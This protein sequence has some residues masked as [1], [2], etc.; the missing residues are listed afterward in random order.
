MRRL[1]R[2][3]IGLTGDAETMFLA[4]AANVVFPGRGL[5]PRLADFGSGLRLRVRAFAGVD[6]S[7][8]PFPADQ[9]DCRPVLIAKPVPGERSRPEGRGEHRADDA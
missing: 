9:M 7:D 4:Q 6:V 3:S 2:H 8:L 1:L 5:T